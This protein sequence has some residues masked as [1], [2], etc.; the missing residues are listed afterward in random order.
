M[1][2]LVDISAAKEFMK[3]TLDRVDRAELISM[4]SDLDAK[5]RHFRYVLSADRIG[6]LTPSDV[7]SLLKLTFATRRHHAQITEAQSHDVLAKEIGNL[8]HG[9]QLVEDRFE[10]FVNQVQG[11]DAGMRTE[12]AGEILHFT[13]PDIYWLWSRWM[14]DPAKKTG[15]IPLLTTEEFDLQGSHP[16]EIYKK[17]GK[18]IAFVHSIGDAAEFRFI[19]NNLFGT[20]VFLACVY[21][22][23]AYTVLRL[24]MTQEFNK[25]MPGLPE[26]TRR[27]LGIYRMPQLVEKI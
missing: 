18:G 2:Q 16:G 15:A 6:Q 13:K 12:L 10:R 3:E 20:D 11:G 1:S 19:S 25:V 26:F 22:V 14:W 7:T 17:V 8:L 27:L 24:R 21:V 23:Y 5:S 4:A 9:D